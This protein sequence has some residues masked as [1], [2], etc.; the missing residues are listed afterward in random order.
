MKTTKTK[1][2]KMKNLTGYN[3]NKFVKAEHVFIEGKGTFYFEIDTAN[4]EF[5]FNNEVGIHL[6]TIQHEG[7]TLYRIAST[8]LFN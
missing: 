1:E 8:N 4:N 2:N 7:T 3:A 6:E 5:D